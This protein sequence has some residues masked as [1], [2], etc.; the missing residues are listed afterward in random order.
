[1]E[2]NLA[3]K[4]SISPRKILFRARPGMVITMFLFWTI[5]SGTINWQHMLLGLLFSL[6]ICFFW[7]DFLLDEKEGLPLNRRRLYLFLIYF[8]D[9]ILEILKANIEVVKIVL[10][11]KLP[12]SPCFVRYK[13]HLHKTLSQVILANS[14]TL[15]PGTLSTFLSGKEIVVHALTRE[16]A[17]A[18]ADW[19]IHD[20]LKMIEEAGK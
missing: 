18:V 13:I 15:T 10:D 14:I 19:K 5:L 20:E 6:F 17:D 4:T 16:G 12:I 3:T 1:M 7:G 11:P 2:K 9:L 8:K